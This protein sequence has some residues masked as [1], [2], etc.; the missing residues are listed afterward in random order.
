MVQ[1]GHSPIHF[2][3][4]VEVFDQI[5]ID[6]SNCTEIEGQERCRD[7]GFGLELIIT[8]QAVYVVVFPGFFVTAGIQTNDGS[9][10]RREPF[11][12]GWVVFKTG[13]KTP[14]AIANG[15]GSFVAGE[16][17]ILINALYFVA[18]SCLNG[19]SQCHAIVQKVAVTHFGQYNRV[20]FSDV[21][22]D[23]NGGFMGT[24]AGKTSAR[25][26]RKRLLGQKRLG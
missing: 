25:G 10:I 20:S 17:G 3:S 8:S 19:T 22:T 15:A 2:Q 6:T 16:I 5:E 13:L 11:G 23:L 26:R 1:N 12:T 24:V 18:C 14:L 7:I 9:K 21:K 4:Q